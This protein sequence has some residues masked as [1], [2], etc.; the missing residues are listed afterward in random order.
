MG[1]SSKHTWLVKSV[2]CSLWLAYS[3][4]QYSKE[5]KTSDTFHQGA[6]TES[7]VQRIMKMSVI[8]CPGWLMR[9]CPAHTESD[10][11]RYSLSESILYGEPNDSQCK[12]VIIAAF[13]DNLKTNGTGI[14]TLLWDNLVV[15]FLFLFFEPEKGHQRQKIS[16]NVLRI[17][18]FIT[19]NSVLFLCLHI[20]E[21]SLI[22]LVKEKKDNMGHLLNRGSN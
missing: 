7:S 19:C 18:S 1:N 8:Y 6:Q 14:E 4:R 5:I 9:S 11:M 12:A 20:D 3:T 2:L 10:G 21:F 13:R 16:V 15:G 17:W 22:H